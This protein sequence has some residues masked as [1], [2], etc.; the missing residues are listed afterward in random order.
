[1]KHVCIKIRVVLEAYLISCF[2]QCLQ[3]YC[4]DCTEC[5]NLESSYSWSEEDDGFE[6]LRFSCL[7][8]NDGSKGYKFSEDK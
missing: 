5:K 3:P 8:E 4:D 7:E 1:M 6:R 2:V